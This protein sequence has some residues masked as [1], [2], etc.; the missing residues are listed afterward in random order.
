MQPD[1]KAHGII[2][3]SSRPKR[4]CN[5]RRAIRQIIETH[6]RQLTLTCYRF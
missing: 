2:H 5:A 6:D 1:D 4:H 3:I